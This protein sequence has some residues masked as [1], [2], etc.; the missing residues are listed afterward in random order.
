[1]KI[2]IVV[3][4]ALLAQAFGTFVHTPFGLKHEDCIIQVPSGSEVAEKYIN[5]IAHTHVLHPDGTSS[6][7][8]QCPHASPRAAKQDSNG[9]WEGWPYHYWFGQS[10]AYFTTPA[11]TRSVT[12]FHATWN[13]PNFPANHSSEGPTLSW[14]IGLQSPTFLDVLQ[15]V[16]EFDGLFDNAF[17]LASWNCCPAGFTFHSTPISPTPGQTING[18]LDIVGSDPHKYQIVSEI[19]GGKSTTLVVNLDSVRP[20]Y[21]W[22]LVINEVYFITH[23]DQLPSNPVKFTITKFETENGAMNV[24]TLPFHEQ[25]LCAYGNCTHPISPSCV[26]SAVQ[27]QNTISIGYY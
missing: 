8:V 23:C 7:H 27:H 21:T 1:M 9:S 5:G 25:Y 2:I 26:G 13:V 3:G 10:Y 20:N 17:D 19:V 14:W 22:S 15:P 11:L 4:F 18:T 6:L 16:L 12:S 24:N